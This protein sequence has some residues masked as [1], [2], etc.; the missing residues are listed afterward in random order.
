MA[1]FWTG[2]AMTE[3]LPSR[4]E[5]LVNKVIV[6]GGP[7]LVRAALA[8]VIDASLTM[9]VVGEV[10]HRDDFED[11]LEAGA[12]P[13]LVLLD[14]SID[15][16][17]PV[18]FTG[19]IREVRAVARTVVFGVPSAQ[20]V[21]AQVRAGATG[22][23]TADV[24]AS[25]LVSALETVSRGGLVIALGTVPSV[26][27]ASPQ[28][29]P[30]PTRDLSAREREVLTMLSRGQDSAS[31]ARDLGLSPLTVKTHITRML[32]K[33]GMRQRGQLVAFA[34][35]SGL[36]VPGRTHTS[37]IGDGLRAAS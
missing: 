18:D 26:D 30:E 17:R 14:S 4:K 8:K 12:D 33:L 3:G 13:D 15:T 7:S 22:I 5:G 16:G 10:A 11:L 37:F 31:I 1:E 9:R 21:D 2:R 32:G 20:E 24:S 28:V 36:I 6:A 34:Y 27:T 35:E 19:L 29:V 23:L 25:Q